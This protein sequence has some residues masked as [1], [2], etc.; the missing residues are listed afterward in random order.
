MCISKSSCVSLTAQFPLSFSVLHVFSSSSTPTKFM[1][2][3]L[4]HYN[5]KLTDN[6]GYNMFTSLKQLRRRDSVGKLFHN[7]KEVS[8]NVNIHLQHDHVPRFNSDY[9][10][11]H[12]SRFT[13][14]DQ[15]NMILN[16]QSFSKM[17]L[18]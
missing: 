9:Q 4:L 1:Y 2:C 15:I 13:Y 10:K 14:V 18:D 11:T 17:S 7:N 6:F 16:R 8:S 3:K 5:C 12:T